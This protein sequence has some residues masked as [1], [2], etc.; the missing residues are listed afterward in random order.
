MLRLLMLLILSQSHNK[1][2]YKYIYIHSFLLSYLN[3]NYF[4]ALH[5]EHFAT[6]E[7]NSCRIDESITL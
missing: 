1:T 2:Y 4:L 3:S 7:I 6:E 5:D